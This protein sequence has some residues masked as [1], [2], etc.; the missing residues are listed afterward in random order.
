MSGCMPAPPVLS[1]PVMQ[2]TGVKQVFRILWGLLSSCVASVWRHA[3]DA[4][5]KV[6][7]VYI[8]ESGN[9]N[10]C[11]DTSHETSYESLEQI[12][13]YDDCDDTRRI[14]SEVFH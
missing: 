7:D 3:E 8:Y 2:S 10:D 11:D 1:E 14:V 12:Y 13:A 9:E 4:S 5:R 6:I